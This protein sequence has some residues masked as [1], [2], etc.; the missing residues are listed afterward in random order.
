MQ[1]AVW[2]HRDLAFR[3]GGV[4]AVLMLLLW[5]ASAYGSPGSA[6]DQQATAS[7]KGSC[8]GDRAAAALPLGFHLTPSRPA[9]GRDVPAFL[10]D[11]LTGAWVWAHQGVGY[12]SGTSY[13]QGQMAASIARTLHLPK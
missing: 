11:F 12:P 1:C 5:P 7:F 8:I 6:R 4:A 2:A 3:V 13:H 9:L 10:D